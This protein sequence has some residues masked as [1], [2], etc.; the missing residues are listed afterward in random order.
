M[1]KKIKSNNYSY[2]NGS[3]NTLKSL[4]PIPGLTNWF[5]GLNLGNQSGINPSFDRHNN[6]C[7]QT[8]GVTVLFI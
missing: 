1:Y 8:P 6:T 2:L 5:K 3:L 4:Y 7:V